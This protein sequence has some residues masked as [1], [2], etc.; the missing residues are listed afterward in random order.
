MELILNI[1]VNIHQEV[2][3]RHHGRVIALLR[4]LLL[5]LTVLVQQLVAEIITESQRS[6]HM[7]QREDEEI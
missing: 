1:F 6:H 4:V 3:I 5:G 7:H 2:D